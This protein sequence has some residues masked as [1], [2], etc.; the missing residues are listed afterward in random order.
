MKVISYTGFVVAIMAASSATLNAQLST[1]SVR[2][3]IRDASGAAVPAASVVLKNLQTGVETRTSSTQTGDYLI[4]DVQ[5]GHYNLQASKEGFTT[6][7]TDEFVL[8]VNQ[9]TTLAGC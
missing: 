8:Q 7:K 9:F 4:L 3:T 6:Q 2:G 1:A 5:P